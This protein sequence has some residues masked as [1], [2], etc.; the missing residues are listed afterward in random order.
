MRVKGITDYDIV[1]YKKPSLFIAFPYC[2]MKCG[3]GKCQNKDLLTR[4]PEYTTT[5]QN[6]VEMYQRNPLTHAVV[7]GGLEPFDSWE[8]LLE[9]VEA[10]RAET[11][12]DIVIYTGYYSY[13]ILDKIKVLCQYPNIIIK[14]GRYI[15]SYPERFDA[16]LGV[17][18]ASD[19]QFAAKL[20]CEPNIIDAL[21]ENNGYC[22]CTLVKND[23]TLCC[24]R[25]FRENDDKTCHCG[26][27][28][29]EI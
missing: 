7:C 26:L 15:Q 10:I 25:N 4:A 2:T 19:N 6:I 8:M 24:C 9:I 27:Y 3:S 1:N 14:F 29:K 18:L 12:D 13:E 5:A 20:N 11:L 22:P 21:I 28:T 16:T 17:T 23:T